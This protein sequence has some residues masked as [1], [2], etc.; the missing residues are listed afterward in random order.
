MIIG[1]LGGISRRWSTMS[2]R[3]RPHR[4]R[5]SLCSFMMGMRCRRGAQ[6]ATADP[7]RRRIALSDDVDLSEPRAHAPDQKLAS[8]MMRSTNCRRLPAFRSARRRGWP[9]MEGIHPAEDAP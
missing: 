2:R 7:R 8:C 5:D 3:R 4:R 1:M 6:S 9:S